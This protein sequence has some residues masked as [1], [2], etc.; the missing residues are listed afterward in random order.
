MSRLRYYAWRAGAVLLAAASG[1]REFTAA[2]PDD[3]RFRTTPST[4]TLRVGEAFTASAEAFGCAGT[5]RLD[6]VWTWRAADAAVVRVDSLTG[7]IT[8][9]AAGRTLVTPVGR[10]YGSGEPLEATVR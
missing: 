2:C 4:R 6:E 8:G 9:V 3:L 1:C 5:R 7:R 10:R